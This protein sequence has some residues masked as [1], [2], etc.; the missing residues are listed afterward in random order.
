MQ[1]IEAVIQPFKLDDVKTALKGLGIG[2]IMISE[3]LEHGGLVVQKAFYRGTE[4]CADIPKVKLEML[5]SS[6]RT[7]EVIEALSRAAR[8]TLPGDDGTILVYE[9]ADGIRIRSG[10]RIQFALA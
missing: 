3:V 10:A 1:K 2:P 6:L 5:V 9:V 7:D 4:Y 8:T